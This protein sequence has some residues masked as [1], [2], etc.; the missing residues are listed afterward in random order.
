MSFFLWPRGP[1][2]GESDTL[3]SSGPAAVGFAI[4]P[5]RGNQVVRVRAIHR[6]PR[7]ATLSTGRRIV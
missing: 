3:A 7:A 6:G 2:Q 1:W 5:R 4:G